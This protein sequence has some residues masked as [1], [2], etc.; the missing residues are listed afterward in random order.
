MRVVHRRRNV[1]SGKEVFPAG[2][3]GRYE[4][5]LVFANNSD[6][7]LDELTLHDV[8]PGTFSL[9]K[10]TVRSSVDGERD[11]KLKKESAPEGIH[12]EW[13]VGRIEQGERIEVTYEIQGDPESEY[14]V[15]DAQDFHGA[16][17][18][19]EVDEEPNLPEWVNPQ[20]PPEISRQ[21]EPD[22]EPEPEP[23]EEGP[24]EEEP[25]EEGPHEEEPEE[26]GPHEEEPEGEEASEEPEA[27]VC[28][29]CGSEAEIGASVCD[30]CSYSF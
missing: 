26:E 17:F 30:V 25:E 15:S 9:E 21:H 4:I 3:A 19:D 8:V 18:G 16:T 7:A 14:K 20:R 29:I 13:S 2:G 5:L 6:S 1:S 11:V 22:P 27:E 23:E 24:H 10:S 12:I 28:P